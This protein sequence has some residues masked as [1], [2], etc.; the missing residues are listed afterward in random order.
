MPNWLYEIL[1]Y[2]E[3]YQN[4]G[5]ILVTMGA[6]MLIIGFIWW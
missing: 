2:P 5:Y 1:Y 6:L 4:L 3:D